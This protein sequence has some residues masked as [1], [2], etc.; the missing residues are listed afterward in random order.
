MFKDKFINFTS[1]LS[2]RNLSMQFIGEEKEI[3]ESDNIQ[4]KDLNIPIFKNE[5]I[6]FT[7]PY[8]KEIEEL[9]FGKTKVIINGKEREIPNF[10]FK[11]EWVN[12][13]GDLERGYFLKYEY[14]DNPKFEF[15]IANEEII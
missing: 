15:L 11:I 6:T 8:S 3:K 7:H 5:K 10:Y 13:K 2:N 9:I 14:S 1:S 4:I 12:E